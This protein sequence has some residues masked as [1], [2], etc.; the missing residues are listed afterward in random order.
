VALCACVFQT[1]KH[2][3]VLADTGTVGGSTD[4]TMFNYVQ[5]FS[6]K[7]LDITTYVTFCY[8]LFLLYVSLSSCI[9]VRNTCTY[10]YLYVYYCVV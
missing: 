1:E 3:L 7:Y 9:F 4:G 6:K 8:V 10:I 2:I 5:L